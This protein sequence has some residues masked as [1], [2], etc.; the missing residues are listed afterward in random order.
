MLKFLKVNAD[1]FPEKHILR[2]IFSVALIEV[3]E[4]NRENNAGL[5]NNCLSQ[6]NVDDLYGLDEC[7]EKIDP[8]LLKLAMQKATQYHGYF[9]NP[10]RE[11]TV[12]L[13]DLARLR[14]C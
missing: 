5:A 1:R 10:S 13:Q 11:M 7:Y 8:S 14:T 2:W 6:V 4:S 12:K 3:Y 9:D